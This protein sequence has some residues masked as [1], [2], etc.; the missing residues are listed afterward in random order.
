MKPQICL[1]ETNKHKN[2]NHK[3]S[4]PSAYFLEMM[5][6]LSMH[7]NA[8]ALLPGKGQLSFC[9]LPLNLADFCD[10]IDKQNMANVTLH[11]LQV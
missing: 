2:I 9:S 6:F 11:D 10:P 1:L 3:L 7:M 5:L 8:L 4:S